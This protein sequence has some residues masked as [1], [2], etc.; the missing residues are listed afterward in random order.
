MKTLEQYFQENYDKNIID[1]AVR[2]Q[3]YGGKVC[4]YIHAHGKDSDTIDFAVSG[5]EL[6]KSPYQISEQPSAP[7]TQ[8]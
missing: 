6:S 2:C 5:N 4:F 8:L 1:H 3:M 7:E